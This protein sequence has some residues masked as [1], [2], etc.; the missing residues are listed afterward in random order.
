MLWGHVISDTLY[1]RSGYQC[2]RAEL[3][4]KRLG[5]LCRRIILEPFMYSS[6][7]TKPLPH[8]L[9]K[10]SFPWPPSPTDEP[11]FL[12]NPADAELLLQLESPVPKR[13]FTFSADSYTASPPSSKKKKL[14]R[15]QG[16]GTSGPTHLPRDENSTSLKACYCWERCPDR[17]E[18]LLTFLCIFNCVYFNLFL[19][20]FESNS[21][22]LRGKW[23]SSLNTIF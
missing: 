7:K 15:N 8:K 11:D 6:L 12:P 22:F 5:L 20:D 13:R 16:E 9:N 19:F 1:F 3:R 21:C 2:M 23:V 4:I 14:T 17:L 10:L 18:W